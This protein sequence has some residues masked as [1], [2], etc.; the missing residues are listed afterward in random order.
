LAGGTSRS[1]GS[2]ASGSSNCSR[3]A[4][5]FASR[6][7]T[8]RRFRLTTVQDPAPRADVRR[9]FISATAALSAYRAGRI[10]EAVAYAGEALARDPTAAEA[11]L[12]LALIALRRQDVPAMIEALRAC[13]RSRS[14]EWIMEGLRADFEKLGMP[15][16]SSDLA[17]RLGGFLRSKLGPLGPA[18]QPEQRRSDHVFANVVGT[19]Y[20]RSFGGNT[21]LFP[22]FIG[23]GP[24]MLL[25]T[26]EAAAV[27]R[28]KFFETPSITCATSSRPGPT[29]AIRPTRPTTR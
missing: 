3:R 18:P 8:T 20:V 12:C 4:E 24:T 11:H 29:R 21:A 9:G 5:R 26:E 27:S 14:G 10:D 22:L 2:R 15:Q 1:I 6:L 17:F 13:A 25:L 16:L 19:S 23:M 7:Q 28:R